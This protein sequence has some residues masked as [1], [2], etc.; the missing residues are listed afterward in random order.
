MERRQ[1]PPPKHPNSVP[2]VLRACDRQSLEKRWPA[3]YQQLVEARSI[4][5]RHFRDVCDL[6][7]S[8]E[9]GRLFILSVRPAKASHVATVR[10]ALELLTEDILTPEDVLQRVSTQDVAAFTRPVILN[11]KHLQ[12]LGTGMGACAGV[13]TGQV[14]LS[15]VEALRLA[16]AGIS[17]ILIQ[18]ELSP[19]DIEAFRAAQGI[20]TLRG[21]V[22][23][24]AAIACQRLNVVGVVGYSP[25][26]TAFTKSDKT[27]DLFR[28]GTWITIDGGTGQVFAGKGR[29]H[30]RHWRKIP[31]LVALGEIIERAII[32][33]HVPP[34]AMGQVWTIRDFLHRS[35]PLVR[36]ATQK[37]PVTRSKF[38]SFVQP[39]PDTL[40]RIRRKLI[41]LDGRERRNYADI[42]LSMLDWLLKALVDRVGIGH[43]PQFFRP[44]WNP[45]Q[46]LQGAQGEPTQLV[47]VEFHDI[48]RYVPNLIDVATITIFLELNLRHPEDEWFLD[49]TNPDGESIVATSDSI[50]AYRLLLNDAEVRHSDLPALYGALR[51]RD[52][53]WP[54]YESNATSHSEMIDCL[55]AWQ[56][57]TALRSPLLP[58]CFELGLIRNR[59]LTD[60]GKSLLG[61]LHRPKRYEYVSSILES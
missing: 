17:T 55:A 35:R 52:Y 7:F 4:A 28:E 13:A 19:R 50:I 26:G 8:V 32:T 10:F 44:L 16:H 24:H 34:N 49:F 30:S 59:R 33:G 53:A 37:Q 58:L 6:E 43:H 18:P 25:T 27:D 61:K 36:G 9:E 46:I 54:F 5:E 12:P 39:R 51:R 56:T 29:C 20:V 22:S 11:A 15:P 48:N 57:N 1:N 41:P 21:G 45:R 42:L 3:V 40:R 31:E 38:T 60:S 2:E 14:A 23:S 47:G